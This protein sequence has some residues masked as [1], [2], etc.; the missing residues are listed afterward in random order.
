MRLHSPDMKSPGSMRLISPPVLGRAVKKETLMDKKIRIRCLVVFLTLILIVCISFLMSVC[1]GNVNIDVK[2]IINIFVSGNT[3]EK[4][5]NIIMN[6]RLPRTLM[7]FVLGGGLA[8]SGFL[9]QTF[10]AN[11]IASSSLTILLSISSIL[12]SIR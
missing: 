4:S 10:F 1:I 5:R 3:D 9:L 2:T 7:T 6:I 11:P 8:V 12:F